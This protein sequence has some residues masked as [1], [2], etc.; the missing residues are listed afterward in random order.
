MIE[1]TGYVLQ[2]CIAGIGGRGDKQ[3]RT[4]STRAVGSKQSYFKSSFFYPK[5]RPFG[6]VHITVA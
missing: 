6:L 1:Y 4:F 5:A 3:E 2:Y